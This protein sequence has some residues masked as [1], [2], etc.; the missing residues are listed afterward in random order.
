MKFKPILDGIETILKADDETKHVIKEYR[1]F[2]FE[3][4]IRATPFCLLGRIARSNYQ[5]RTTL[6]V[7]WDGEIT[8]TFLGRAYDVPNQKRVEVLEMLDTL[9]DNAYDVFI[10]QPKLNGSVRTSHVSEKR[11]IVINEYFGFEIILSFSVM[12]A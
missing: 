6:G 4:G 3:P 5:G 1:R 10:A 9:Q 11:P 2:I 7:I 8:V 12:V